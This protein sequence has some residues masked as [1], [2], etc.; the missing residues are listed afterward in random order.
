MIKFVD[1]EKVI[2]QSS[3]LKQE[4]EHLNKVKET[5]LAGKKAAE[6][7]Y[8]KMTKEDAQKSA[9]ADKLL[10][11]RSWSQQQKQ[12]RIS[13]LETIYAAAEQYRVENKIA[14]I[15][16]KTAIIAGDTSADISD[17]IITLLKEQQVKY[18]PLPEIS[19]RDT[20]V[21]SAQTQKQE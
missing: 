15:T 16:H 8:E 3:L 19:T 11:E 9:L 1:V 10:L 13:T 4:S 14:V 5:L 6:N 21:T 12:A 2:S 18:A 7:S 17:Q 20:N